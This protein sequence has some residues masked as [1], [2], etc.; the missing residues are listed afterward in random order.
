[1]RGHALVEQNP[2]PTRDEIAHDLRAHLCRCTGY[3]KIVDAIEELANVSRG[4]AP[5][6]IEC[7]GK[8]G[9]SLR[10]YK[11]NDLVLGDFDYIDDITVPGMSYAAM[12]FSDHPRA[13][14]KGIDATAALEMDGV[15]RVITAADVPGDRYVGLIVKDW[16]ILV[17][18][19]EE[20]RCVGDIIAI[21]VARDQYIARKAAEKI[22]VDYEVRKPITTP[23]E[24][25]KPDAHQIHAKGNLLSKIGNCAGQSGR[26]VCQSGARCGRHI[27]R[28]SGSSTCFWSRNRALRFRW[29][30]ITPR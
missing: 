22:V 11:A 1:M 13:L 20:T 12:K 23:D 25:L 9:T 17:A 14:V 3:V 16:P 26:S 8:V 10:K 24:A 30:N 15:E 19:G 6:E 18:I 4:E 27:S 7:S 29:T 2:N 28:R 5:R 21:V